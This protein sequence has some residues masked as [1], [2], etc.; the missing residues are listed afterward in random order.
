[1]EIRTLCVFC[2]SNTGANKI[3]RVAAQSMGRMLVRRG[4]RL[5]YGGGSVGLMGVLADTVLKQGGHVTGII[6]TALAH[7]DVLHQGLSETHVTDN[8]HE[9][10]AKMAELSDAFVAMP[11][12]YGTLEEVFEVVTWA[13]LGLHNKPL[14]IL[15]TGGYYDGL[16]DCIDAAVV[17]G[18]IKPEH[19]K[20]IIV[21]SEPDALFD[22]LA[23]QQ[24]PTVEKWIRAQGT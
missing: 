22:A 16:L 19:R 13:Q 18:F 20:L 23:R 11:G 12:G 15:N 1:M 17:E 10:K 3:Y 5:V 24:P 21:G 7:K 6:P 2:G 4:C 14:G 9:R 8:M